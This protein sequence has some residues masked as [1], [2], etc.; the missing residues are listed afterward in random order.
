VAKVAPVPWFLVLFVGFAALN[1]TGLIPAKALEVIRNADLW[2]LCVGMAGVGLQTGF[3][4]LRSAGFRP[5]A[6][7]ALQWLVLSVVA[8]GLTR[9]WCGQG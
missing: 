3:G 6:A 4:D 5:I 8:Y 2:L 1:S 7:G 9:W